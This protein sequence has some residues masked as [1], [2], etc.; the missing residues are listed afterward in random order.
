ML[1]YGARDLAR[2]FRTVRDNTLA[3]VKEIP[4]DKLDFL[5]AKDVRTIG[6]LLSH[7]AFGDEFSYAVHKPGRFTL[8]EIN[9][10]EF[11]GRLSVLEAEPRDKVALEALLT[12]RGAA[13]ADWLETLS[14]EFLSEPVAMPPGQTPA[15]KTRF[16]LLMGVK[17]HEMHHRGQLM[18]LLRLLG[19]VPP[20]TR[21]RQEMA[22]RMAAEAA[23]K[24]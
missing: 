16:E 18:L 4:A 10:P 1:P 21:H 13:F 24:Q 23:G 6:Q 2:A 22:A 12:E 19:Q 17:E 8:S 20:L 11:M 3:I 14:D 5:P 7:I 9:F 15:A